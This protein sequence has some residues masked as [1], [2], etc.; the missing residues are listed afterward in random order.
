[1]ADQVTV[2]GE[3]TPEYIAW[4]LMEKIF[5]AENKGRDN[6]NREEILST[7]AECVKTVRLGA[8]G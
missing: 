6:L 7:Y 8:Y 1:M 5:S 2:Q 3:N 4:R